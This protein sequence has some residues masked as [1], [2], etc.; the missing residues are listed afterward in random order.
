ML[1]TSR[2]RERQLGE[3]GVP[4]LVLCRRSRKAGDE[5]GRR[6]GTE[7][8][9]LR[10]KNAPTVLVLREMGFPDGVRPGNNPGDVYWV[11]RRTVGGVV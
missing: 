3:N 1:Q 4:A 10:I 9:L 6:E 5:D 11:Y 2:L 8:L 7:Q